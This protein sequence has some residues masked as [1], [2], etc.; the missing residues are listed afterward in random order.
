LYPLLKEIHLEILDLLLEKGA[1]L[2]KVEEGI[3]RRMMDMELE[4]R[5]SIVKEFEDK[6]IQKFNE[7]DEEK[8]NTSNEV[9]ADQGKFVVSERE[10]I[11]KVAHCEN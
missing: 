11:R 2:D 3:L 10:A 4:T 7:I 8:Q 5:T 9:I 1:R 6:L